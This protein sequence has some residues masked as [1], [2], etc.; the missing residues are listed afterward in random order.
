MATYKSKEITVTAPVDDVF[1]RVT[2]LGAFQQR[3]DQLPE[4]LRA[5]MGSV[6]FGQDSIIIEAAPMGEITFRVTERIP[7]QRITLAAEQSPVPLTLSVVTRGNIADSNAT[8]IQTVIDV[9]IPPMLKP[10]VGG[11]LQ[12]AADMFTDMLQKIFLPR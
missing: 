12:Q 3:L 6:R 1:A 10:L 5:R 7:S 11:K 8:D 9:D 4:D 2:D